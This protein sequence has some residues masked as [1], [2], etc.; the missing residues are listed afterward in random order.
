MSAA[1][2]FPTALRELTTDAWLLFVTRFTRLFAY[3]SLS[4]ILVFYL[5]SL[6]LS[7]PQT[8]L[9]LTLTLAGDLVV[10]LYLTTR[11]DR[12]GRRRMLVVGAVL[13]TLAGLAFAFTS[14][15]IYLIIAG[16]IGV[17]SPSGH[18][19]GPFLSIEQ[20]SLSHLIPAELRTEIFAWYTLTGSLAT[21][22]GALFGGVVSQALRHSMSA[23]T[24]YRS[25]VLL[26]AIL[27][28]ALACL[29]MRLSSLVE[30]TNQSDASPTGSFMGLG[31][32]RNVV[33][34]LSALFALDSFGGGFV[35]QSFA[36]YW[37]YLRFGA[38]PK[39]LGGIF[40]SANVFAG[41][42]ALLASRLATRIGLV[43]TMV[44]T[45]LPSNL[46]LIAVPLMPTLRLAVL[47]L[48]LRFSISQMDV[49]TRQSFTMA[50]VEARERSAAGGFTG[51]A[52]TTG[53]A[54]SPLLT[55]FL[56]AR[57]SLVNLP[58]YIAGTLK[59]VY[60]LLIY[61]SFRQLRPPEESCH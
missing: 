11:A 16:T 53:A 43:R 33:L 7:E 17:I 38:E 13:M 59:V 26:Y 14:N 50:V 4:V 15:L 25:I 10:S 60:D 34:K 46:L 18:E 24:S 35:V 22:L 42:S 21:A 37:F 39:T 45:H 56:F 12:I 32:S 57:P 28:V 54:I 51:V 29:F 6:G 47:V 19:V 1:T 2:L 5:V 27:G 36:A 20:A 30:V 31:K 49:P 41:I 8:G 3:G 40:F 52:R 55:G 9:V 48:L 61:F 44:V 23:I 58:F